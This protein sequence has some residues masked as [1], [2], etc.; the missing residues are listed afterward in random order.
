[1]L[2]PGGFLKKVFNAPGKVA[3]GGASKAASLIAKKSPPS[4]NKGGVAKMKSMF[5]KKA[6]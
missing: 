6:S 5:A 1:M 2:K 4:S 3:G